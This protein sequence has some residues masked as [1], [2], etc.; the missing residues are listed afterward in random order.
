MTSTTDALSALALQVSHDFAGTP[1]GAVAASV[2][3]SL[4]EPLRLAI[5]GRVK[6]GKSTLLNAMVGEPLAPTDA[7]ECTRV[8]TWYRYGR[9][10]SAWV[11]EIDGRRRQVP[12]T[13]T[14]DSLAVEL[15]CSPGRARRLEI[16]WPAARL[17]TM[18]LVDTPGIG[19]T[20]AA[21]AHKAREL[22]DEDD[23]D[24]SVDAVLFL[25]NQVH[26][27]DWRFLE[28]FSDRA[29]IRPDPS[30]A[31][32]LLSRADE[33]AGAAPDALAQATRIASRL[34][35]DPAVRR[36]CQSVLA[37]S[38]LMAAG[39]AG[40]TSEQHRALC[41]LAADPD[42]DERLLTAS[43]FAGDGSPDVGGVELGVRRSLLANLGLF[44]VRETVALLRDT[45]GASAS[46]LVSTY[47]TASG[48]DELSALI[49]RRFLRRRDVLRARRAIA[50]L[51]AAARRHGPGCDQVAAALERIEAGA[52]ELAE[53]QV[54]AA[55]RGGALR[56]RDEAGADL[57]TILDGDVELAAPDAARTIEQWRAFA[58]HPLT[59][60]AEREAALVVARAAERSLQSELGAR[61]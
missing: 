31:V 40:L 3:S 20:D 61:R 54:L 21:T 11:E 14:G 1:L 4:R 23:P 42:V 50:S 34:A 16:T 57:E 10:R 18:T 8:V 6:A 22:G 19:S 12:V 33:V 7:G 59:G 13:A 28:T 2:R 48:L 27:D 49:D 9:T 44:A 29:G 41:A 46:E 38:S 25:T 32:A 58:E 55:W 47:R 15:G 35:G 17:E 51:W 36:R 39:A 56:L 43:R 45:P 5:A 53:V 26:P 52:H 30:C 37:I 24:R 60:R